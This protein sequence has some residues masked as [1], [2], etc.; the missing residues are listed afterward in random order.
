MGGGSSKNAEKVGDI[1]KSAGSYW[2]NYE[3]FFL[4]NHL[5]TIK[6]GQKNLKQNLNGNFWTILKI[7]IFCQK[8][9]KVGYIPMY[10]GSYWEN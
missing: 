9:Q 6:K 4:K 2:E 5:E 8:C 1:P 3:E 7:H 10:A